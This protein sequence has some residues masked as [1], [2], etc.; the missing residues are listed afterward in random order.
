[1][2]QPIQ[3]ARRAVGESG[4]CSSMISRRR[5]ASAGQARGESEE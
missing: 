2:L 5:N 1:M 3:P 4:F